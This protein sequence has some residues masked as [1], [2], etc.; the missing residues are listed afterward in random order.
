MYYCN[1][2]H[3]ITRELERKETTY[4][5][6]YGVDFLFPDTHT[7]T[8]EVCPYCGAEIDEIEEMQKCDIC[9]EY[10]RKDY[11]EEDICKDCLENLK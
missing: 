2:C 11:L 5:D 8:Y 1:K 4:E 10:Y 3:N 9:K 7:M 6:F